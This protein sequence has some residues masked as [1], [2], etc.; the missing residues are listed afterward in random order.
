[1]PPRS[2]RSLRAGS[3]AGSSSHAVSREPCSSGRV[4]STHTCASK[5]PLPRRDGARR[6][7]VPYPPVA[8]PPALQCVRARVAG[9]EQVGRVRRHPPAALDLLLVERARASGVGSSAH[10]V[11]RPG[12]VHRRRP[13][14]AR[15]PRRPRRG[16]P[17][18]RPR[19]RA[20][21][22]QRRRSPARR[23]SPASGSR[24]RPPRP[25]AHRARPPRPEAALVEQDDRASSS[26]ANDLFGS[27][28]GV[29][30]PSSHEARYLACSSVS[31]SISTPIVSSLS[32]AIS[33]SMSSGT[34]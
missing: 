14:G 25:C 4:S 15:A 29:R 12:E 10:L 1:M 8:S 31:W 7:R 5:P 21:R 30:C 24:R 19:A 28:I 13:R 22:P 6:P 17:H 27:S 2:R 3:P 34:G 11:E 32:R 33:S 20:R 16:P 26:S 9:R 18:A 23:E